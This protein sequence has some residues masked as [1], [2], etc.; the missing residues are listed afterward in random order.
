[1]NLQDKVGVVAGGSG[2]I[3]SATAHRLAEAGAKVVVGYNSRL[4]RANAVVASLPGT[5][6]R[7]LRIPMLETPLMMN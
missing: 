3:G 4:E 6:H 7:V 2:A 1:M 5:G